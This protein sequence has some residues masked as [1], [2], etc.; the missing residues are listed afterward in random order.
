M[1]SYYNIGRPISFLYIGYDHHM[2]K[3]FSSP[4]TYFWKS[5][6]PLGTGF[7]SV[8]KATAQGGKDQQYLC[9]QRG[10]WI[11]APFSV[12]G[13]VPFISFS[14]TFWANN[15]EDIS[16]VHRTIIRA[17]KSLPSFT[18]KIQY[19]ASVYNSMRKYFLAIPLLFTTHYQ[20]QK[21]N[22]IDT[23]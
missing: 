11:L 17:D 14:Y 15:A 2:H 20:L 22:Y 5:G 23:V 6:E 8:E 21:M 7:K 19:H 18:N 4:W 1:Q 3:C 13:I 9:M 10:V 16:D 12:V